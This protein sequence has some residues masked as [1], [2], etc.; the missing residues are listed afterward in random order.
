MS[1][2]NLFISAAL[3]MFVLVILANVVA[4]YAKTQNTIISQPDTRPAPDH[5]QA[6]VTPK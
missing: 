1:K 6:F 3:T 5:S 2:K 4:G